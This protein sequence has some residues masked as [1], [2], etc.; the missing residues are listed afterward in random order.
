MKTAIFIFGFGKDAYEPIG[1]VSIYGEMIYD[2]SLVDSFIK[3][4]N[5]VGGRIES[6]KL[7]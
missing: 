4:Y 1:S 6:I 2:D 5:E 3:K 7:E